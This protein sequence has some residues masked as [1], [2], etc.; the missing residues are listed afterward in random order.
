[1][2]KMLAFTSLL[3]VSAGLMAAPVAPQPAPMQHQ[4]AMK[5]QP[6]EPK[7]DEARIPPRPMAKPAPRMAP[8]RLMKPVKH[9]KKAP[10]KL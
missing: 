8:K 7:N 9:W 10:L 3:M 5:M 6:G 2:K 1:M 4:H